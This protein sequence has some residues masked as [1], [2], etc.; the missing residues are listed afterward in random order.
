MTVVLLAFA[1]YLNA[2]EKNYGSFGTRA[3]NVV[4]N[5]DTIAEPPLSHT[6]KAFVTENKFG[7]D[8]IGRKEWS[9]RFGEETMHLE[10]LKEIM[11]CRM[12]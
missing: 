1:F 4:I 2:E 9:K 6:K 12:Q 11:A 7:F 3:D 8:T 10:K 5:A